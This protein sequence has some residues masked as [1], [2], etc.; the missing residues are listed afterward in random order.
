MPQLEFLVFCLAALWANKLPL[1]STGPQD[2]VFLP[3][4]SAMMC[5]LFTLTAVLNALPPSPTYLGQR[6]LEC[7]QQNP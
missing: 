6:V 4:H 5:H 3:S 2:P 7:H 1:Q